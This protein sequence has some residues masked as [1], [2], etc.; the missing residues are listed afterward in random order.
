MAYSWNPLR[1]PRGPPLFIIGV[2]DATVVEPSL[3]GGH[4]DGPSLGPDSTGALQGYEGALR[5]SRTNAS[6]RSL[7]SLA[8]AVVGVN[9][10]SVV[11]EPWWSADNFFLSTLHVTCFFF[12]ALSDTSI[13]QRG[14]RRVASRRPRN[15]HS[16]VTVP[17]PSAFAEPARCLEKGVG[18]SN[19]SFLCERDRAT[20]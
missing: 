8:R 1:R 4:T 17:L 2:N 15:V 5:E 10:R 6:T 16:P 19:P 20:G 13:R 14:R 11:L 3:A 7:A 18:L 9:V 12:L